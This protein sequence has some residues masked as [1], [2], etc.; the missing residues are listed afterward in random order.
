MVVHQD[1]GVQSAACVEQGLAQKHQVALPIVIIQ[2]AGQP[3]VAALDNVLRNVGQVEPRLSGHLHR[4]GASTA[5][6]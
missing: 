5:R 4:I 3:I 6:R 2:K 1:V